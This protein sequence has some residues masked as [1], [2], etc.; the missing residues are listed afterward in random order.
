[1][2]GNR[3][4]RSYFFKVFG[5]GDRIRTCD[6]RIW[7]SA[8][9]QLSYTLAKDPVP[10]RVIHLLECHQGPLQGRQESNPRHPTLEAGAL[11]IELHPC[12]G[13]CP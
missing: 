5:K 4:L 13:P 7:S 10:L 8:L 12:K 1:M 3:D 11:P 9:Y 2:A 6:I